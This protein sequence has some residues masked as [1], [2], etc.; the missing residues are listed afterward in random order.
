MN[1]PLT[2][3]LLEKKFA[4]SWDY[5]EDRWM[6]CNEGMRLAADWQLEQMIEYF[7]SKILDAKCGFIV[8][9]DERLLEFEK[10]MRPQQQENN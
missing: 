3:D 7:K 4:P 8:L 10:A 5:D 2:D 1:H 9:N 6:Y